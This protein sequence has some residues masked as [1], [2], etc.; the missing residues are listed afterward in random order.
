MIKNLIFGTGSYGGFNPPPPPSPDK[1]AINYSTWNGLQNPS[2]DVCI[3]TSTW[4][5]VY[6]STL[7]IST[8]IYEWILELK[9]TE[10]I[11]DYFVEIRQVQGLNVD[12]PSSG[13]YLLDQ[14]VSPS[15]RRVYVENGYIKVVVVCQ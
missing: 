8:N 3:T 14:L 5:A 2:T 11:E 1:A 13:W 10:N 7:S 9:T 12:I 4:T 15:V 6:N